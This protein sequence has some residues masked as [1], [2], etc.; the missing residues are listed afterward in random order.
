MLRWM[1]DYIG[2]MEART[3]QTLSVL[4]YNTDDLQHH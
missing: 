1:E 4:I 3:Q 2:L